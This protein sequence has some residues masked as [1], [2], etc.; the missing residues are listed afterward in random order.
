MLVSFL[1]PQDLAQIQQPMHF[2]QGRIH[3][4]CIKLQIKTDEKRHLI[5]VKRQRKIHYVEL[6]IC[7]TEIK[8]VHIRKVINSYFNQRT[9]GCWKTD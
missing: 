5:C 7:D 2:S 6:L 1:D 8:K 3:S 4:K 9:K